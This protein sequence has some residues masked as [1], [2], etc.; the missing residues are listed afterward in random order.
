MTSWTR[1]RWSLPNRWHMMAEEGGGGEA[2]ITETADVG[3]ADPGSEGGKATGDTEGT[4]QA[5]PEDWRTQLTGG[6]EKLNN[7]AGR[8]ATP[9]DVFTGLVAAQDKIRSGD[10]KAPFPGEGTE[11][12]QKTWRSENGIPDT[13]DGYDMKFDSGLVIGEDDQPVVDSFLKDVAHA[14]N[15]KPSDAKAAVEWYYDTQQH[16][17]EAQQEQDFNDSQ[18][19]VDELNVEWGGDYRRN[20]NM[21]EGVIG[22]FPEAVQEDLRSARMPDGTALL[23]NPDALRGLVN[24]A[25]EINP[26]GP[27]VPMGTTNVVDSVEDQIT[28]IETFMKEHR[29]DYNKDEKMQSKLRDLYD[30]REGFKKKASRVVPPLR[31]GFSPSSEGLLL[32]RILHASCCKLTRA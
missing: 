3:T 31:S 1:M 28:E 32:C 25:L 18:K 27:L 29:R 14:N 17:I 2:A 22:K 5:W 19:S 23:N 8:Y 11:E 9:K 4:P 30:A 24:L 13:P 26:A 16:Q 6:D 20:I 7:I 12:E 21:I 10:L 15:M